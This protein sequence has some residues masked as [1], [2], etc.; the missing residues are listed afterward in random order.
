[1][2]CMSTKFG[3]KLC[4]MFCNSSALEEPVIARRMLYGFVPTKPFDK[5]KGFVSQRL[6]YS[7]PAMT[8]L[9]GLL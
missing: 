9:Y 7:F 8:I 3:T 6:N 5:L 2:E 1:M 4:V